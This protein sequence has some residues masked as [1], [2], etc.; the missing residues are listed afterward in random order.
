M[1]V[2]VGIGGLWRRRLWWHDRREGLWV[3][4]KLRLST[5][6]ISNGCGQYPT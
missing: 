2:R 1:A 4:G 5:D 3:W 6:D